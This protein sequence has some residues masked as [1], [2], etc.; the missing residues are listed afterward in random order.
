MGTTRLNTANLLV[1][2]T[3]NLLVMD[4]NIKHLGKNCS[5]VKILIKIKA[6]EFHLHLIVVILSTKTIP[7]ILPIAILARCVSC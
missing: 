7:K 3:A 6:E 1:K 5:Y 4:C 2:L